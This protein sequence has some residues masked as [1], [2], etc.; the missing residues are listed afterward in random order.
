M[1]E[2][3]N[4]VQVEEGSGVETWKLHKSGVKDVCQSDWHQKNF[5]ILEY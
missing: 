5:K 3:E 1:E 2:L 4:W